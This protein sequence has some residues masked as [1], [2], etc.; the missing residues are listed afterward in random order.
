[1]TSLLLDTNA[2]LWAVGD[3]GRL[4]EAARS[5]ISDSARAVFV[6]PIS[7]AE[8]EIKRTIGKLRI[9]RRCEEL[10]EPIDAAWL[11]LTGAHV[12]R[13]RD[14]PLHHRDPFDR[15]LIAQ[16][17]AEGLTVVTGDRR[18]AQYDIVRIDA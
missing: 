9:E 11:P 16:A 7:A 6:S 12:D 18:F 4:S 5:A 13:L 2:W 15:I 8:V 10:L 17:I 3:P 1:V 14:L